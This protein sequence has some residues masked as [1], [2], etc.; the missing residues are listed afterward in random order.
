MDTRYVHASR[1]L[2]HKAVLVGLL[3]SSKGGN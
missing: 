2:V 1:W 3:G